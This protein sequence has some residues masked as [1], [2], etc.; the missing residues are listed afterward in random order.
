MPKQRYFPGSEGER[1]QWLKNSGTV[2]PFR[3]AP[4]ACLNSSL[5]ETALG[6]KCIANVECAGLTAL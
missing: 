6:A 4:G 2:D 1:I 5:W 3:I